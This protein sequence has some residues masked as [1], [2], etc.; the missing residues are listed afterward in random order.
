MSITWPQRKVLLVRLRSQ[1]DNICPLVSEFN[2]RRCILRSGLVM[3]L[4]LLG[5][6]VPR[7]DLIMG[8]I[9]GCLTGPLMF[10]LP[11]ILYY[12]LKKQQEMLPTPYVVSPRNIVRDSPPS[13]RFSRGANSCD[14]F[15]ESVS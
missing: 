7:F 1:L 5:E 11:P 8:L 13:L 6:A 14:A 3:F 4:V 9:G 2:R 12:K 15:F 10:I